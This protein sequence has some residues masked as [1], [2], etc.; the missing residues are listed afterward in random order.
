M[1]TVLIYAA[2]WTGMVMLA[3]LNGV[4]RERAYGRFMR[5]LISHQIST[6]VGLI[7]FGVYIWVL[8]GVFKIETS[9]QAL[10][11]G[12]MWLIMTV[13]FEFGFGHYIMKHS[14]GKLIHDYN[15][16]DGRVWLLILIWTAIAPYLFYHIRS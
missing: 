9:R 11:I 16:F 14:W 6:L 2:S 10:L 12:G 5:E 3:I 4:L 8:T 15:I 7:L 1:K 13:S